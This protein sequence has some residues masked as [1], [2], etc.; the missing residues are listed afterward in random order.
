MF[1][2]NSCKLELVWYNIKLYWK[3][4]LWDKKK[5]GDLVSLLELNMSQES[6]IEKFLQSKQGQDFTRNRTSGGFILDNQEWIPER[7]YLRLNYTGQD[8][9][10]L[11]EEAL[12]NTEGIISL[13]RSI[14]KSRQANS[15][16]VLPDVYIHGKENSFEYLIMQ[17]CFPD[18][19]EPHLRFSLK[20]PDGVNL[21]EYAVTY[22]DGLPKLVAI[23]LSVGR[24]GLEGETTVETHDIVTTSG[25]KG[26]LINDRPVVADLMNNTI[27]HQETNRGIFMRKDDKGQ[28][29]FIIKDLNHPN[30]GTVLVF[31]ESIEMQLLREK[32]LV[33]LDQLSETLISISPIEVYRL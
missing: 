7:N 11:T 12:L 29:Y 27:V 33:P 28:I 32:I 1:L 22:Q 23:H 9:S 16:G 8:S 18:E 21:D 4:Q 3:N 20:F 24:K 31:K 5:L 19:T 2:P 14:K 13:Q 10:K 6:I 26:L 25:W 17:D 15:T 30:K